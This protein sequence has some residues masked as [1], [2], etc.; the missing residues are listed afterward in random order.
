MQERV[1]RE[2]DPC[3]TPSIAITDS[4]GS[5]RPPL[6]PVPVCRPELPHQPPADGGHLATDAADGESVE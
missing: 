6:W 3:A 5:S 1:I 4:F 2:A